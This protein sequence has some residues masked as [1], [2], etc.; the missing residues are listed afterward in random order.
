MRANHL[1]SLLLVI[2][3]TSCELAP[4]IDVSPARLLQSSTS[5][6]DRQGNEVSAVGYLLL[7]FQSDS[8]LVALA[9]SRDGVLRQSAETCDS[10]T[11]LEGWPYVFDV[12]ENSYAVLVA[13]KATQPVAY[14]LAVAPEDLCIR[15]GIGGTMSPLAL[16]RSTTLR[17]S[18]NDVLREELRAYES[19]S[20]VVDLQL[21]PACR[22]R[23]CSPASQGKR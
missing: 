13:W 14:N 9:A 10:Q 12:A 22:E 2:A 3:L 11:A 8:D 7:P 20:G 4:A 17:F 6:S 23:M 21:S 18:L 5:V 1:P 15:V 19:Q 16:A